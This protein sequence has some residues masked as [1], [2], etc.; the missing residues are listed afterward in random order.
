MLCSLLLFSF[1]YSSL[2]G[3]PDEGPN[4]WY[5]LRWSVHIFPIVKWFQGNRLFRSVGSTDLSNWEL[6]W[7]D[8]SQ[9]LICLTCSLI[10]RRSDSCILSVNWGEFK[11]CSNTSHR[12]RETQWINRF[13][14]GWFGLLELASCESVLFVLSRV[15][16][17]TVGSQHPVFMTLQMKS[18]VTSRVGGH[19]EPIESRPAS[20]DVL[21]DKWTS[22]HLHEQSGQGYHPCPKSRYHP[23]IAN[24]APFFLPSGHHLRSEG[25]D[26]TKDSSIANPPRIP[27]PFL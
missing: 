11:I 1:S 2:D 19:A 26:Q 8:F 7:V 14:Y 16:S 21:M 9:V 20:W 22:R 24:I 13:R 6:A 10:L 5:P 12:P 23:T 25:A 17:A 4:W 3:L 18:V 27:V 15:R